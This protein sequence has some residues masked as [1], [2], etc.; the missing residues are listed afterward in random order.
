MNESES[1]P[2]PQANANQDAEKRFLRRKILGALV[3]LAILLAAVGLSGHFFREEV[4]TFANVIN[5]RLGFGGLAGI[6]FL[7]ETIVS[8]LPPDIIL[9]IV[10]TSELNAEWPRRIA[11]LGILSVLGG[12]LGWFLGG[13]V[14]GTRVARVLMGRYRR[15]SVLVTKRYG[16]WAIVL[17]AL[18]P[19]PWSITC[20][21]AG[22]L[23]M[24]WSRFLVASLVRFPRIFVYYLIIQATLRSV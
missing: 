4:T 2:V 8:P 10:A 21:T 16:S 22:I 19:L 15:R 5:D 14:G 23:R 6:F 1:S 9:W 11:L 7:S 17:A 3:L 13:H 20:W 12:H 18:T 24:D